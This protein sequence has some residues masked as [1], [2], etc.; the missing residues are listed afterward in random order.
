MNSINEL[1]NQ[2]TTRQVI[3]AAMQ[4]SMPDDI[5]HEFGIILSKV[6]SAEQELVRLHQYALAGTRIVWDLP[7]NVRAR[8]VTEIKQRLV[9]VEKTINS[10]S[11]PAAVRKD[12]RAEMERLMTE[13]NS[14]C[15]QQVGECS[16][17]GAFGLLKI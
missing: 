11:T 4:L 5:K 17:T 9:V 13:L 3:A 12:Y 1:N 8:R 15:L 2:S 7:E 10:R 14:L 16:M 6:E